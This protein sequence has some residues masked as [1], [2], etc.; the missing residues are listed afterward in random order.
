MA[1]EDLAAEPSAEEKWQ[2]EC[3]FREREL[4][5][6]EEEGRLKAADL[7]LRRRDQEQSKWRN[8][9]VIAIGAAA[10]AA[11]GN[12]VIAFV[13]SN[14]AVNL[15]EQRSEQARILE[16]LKTGDRASARGN[17]QFLL[18]AGL[19]RRGSPRA[20]QMAAY[21]ERTKGRPNVGPVLSTGNGAVVQRPSSEMT[22]ELF[23]CQATSGAP[24]LAER[25]LRLRPSDAGPWPIR[26]WSMEDNQG[27]NFQVNQN[28]IRYNANEAAVAAQL[29]ALF[30]RRLGV[31]MVLRENRQ[32][33]PGYLSVFFCDA[34]FTGSSNTAPDSGEVN[35]T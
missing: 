5:I 4:G 3:G 26:S 32:D 18:E 24:G 27:Q 34:A 30:D 13:N 33:T 25:A 11:L 6:K 35:A 31:Q 15:E 19:I 20:E 8:P 28:E 2:T 22:V 1:K 9:L 10:F 17:L 29:K 21:L 23:Y 14:A 16:M 7:E 12:A